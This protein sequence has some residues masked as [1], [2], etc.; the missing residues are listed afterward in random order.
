MVMTDLSVL[1]HE[2]IRRMAVDDPRADLPHADAQAAARWRAILSGDA[3]TFGAGVVY[4]RYGV[5]GPAG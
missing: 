4:L 1:G 5:S 3:K 2:I